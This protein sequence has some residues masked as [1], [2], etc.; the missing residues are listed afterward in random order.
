MWYRQVDAA[1]VDFQ[2]LY[3]Y[4]GDASINRGYENKLTEVIPFVAV[5]L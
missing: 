2:A 5:V 3:T 1:A 4:V